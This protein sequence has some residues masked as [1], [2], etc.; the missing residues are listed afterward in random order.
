MSKITDYRSYL[1]YFA[2]LAYAEPELPVEQ[3]TGRAIVIFDS[4][5]KLGEARSMR[6]YPVLEVERPSGRI[7]A[8]PSTRHQ[9]IWTA[10][11]SVLDHADKDDE[12]KQNQILSRTEKIVDRLV[13]RLLAD[14]V[15]SENTL[16][17]TPV[18]N[19]Q[20][21]TLYGW[22]VSF[23]IKLHP[24]FCYDGDTWYKFFRLEPI[25]GGVEGVL[26]LNINGELYETDWNQE[27]QAQLAMKELSAFI[28]GHDHRR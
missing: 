27:E 25:W 19:V 18:Q 5:N 22:A 24:S 15:V 14:N 1:R 10:G 4:Y 9:K 26:S 13:T 11:F 23:S 20:G 12:H 3:E 8:A 16:E 28:I 17:I 7:N 2:N 6:A 21:D